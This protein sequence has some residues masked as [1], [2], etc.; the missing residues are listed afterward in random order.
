MLT[1]SITIQATKQTGPRSFISKQVP[2]FMI[3][4]SSQTEAEAVA[5]DIVNRDDGTTFVV[6]AVEI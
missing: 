1:Y 6:C 2:A 5:L 3:H 4:A